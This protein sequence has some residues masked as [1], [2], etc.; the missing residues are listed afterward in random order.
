MKHSSPFCLHFQ[1][2]PITAF[3]LQS[4]NWSY[5]GSFGS[6]SFTGKSELVK[7]DNAPSLL[8][9]FHWLPLVVPTESVLTDYIR[10][11]LVLW[12]FPESHPCSLSSIRLRSL[13]TS[14]S[15]VLKFTWTSAFPGPSIWNILLPFYP[16]D[17][18]LITVVRESSLSPANGKLSSQDSFYITSFLHEALITTTLF[19][20][21]PFGS[22]PPEYKF[23]GRKDTVFIVHCPTSV[24]GAVPGPQQALDRYLLSGRLRKRIYHFALIMAAVRTAGWCWLPFAWYGRGVQSCAVRIEAGI[25]NE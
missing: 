14:F 22:P 6:F 7:T 2:P 25:S 13:W 23:Q 10:H 24:P 15:D 21:F 4:F 5:F 16:W 11:N 18:A 1:K 3:L 9:A 20:L 19:S 17:F 8:E 12:Y